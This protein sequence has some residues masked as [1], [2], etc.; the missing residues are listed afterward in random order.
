MKFE[1][2]INIASK[3][4]ITEKNSKGLFL[5]RYSYVIL[6]RAQRNN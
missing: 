2:D 4:R 1:R 5:R 3:F 6:A